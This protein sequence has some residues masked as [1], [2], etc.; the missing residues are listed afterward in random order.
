M[1]KKTLYCIIVILLAGIIVLVCGIGSSWFTNGDIRTWFNSWGQKDSVGNSSAGSSDDDNT[2]TE[3]KLE[4]FAFSPDTENKHISLKVTPYSVAVSSEEDDDGGESGD[5]FEE[6]GEDVDIEPVR[7]LIT[8]TV[9]TTVK[10]PKIDWTIE[11]QDPKEEEIDYSNIITLE[12]TEDGANTAIVTC[13]DAFDE[14]FIIK[15]TL[16]DVGVYGSCKVEFVGIPTEIYIVAGRSL[17]AIDEYEIDDIGTIDFTIVL[18]NVYHK[19]GERFYNF[20]SHSSLNGIVE[21]ETLD[22][23]MLGF[24]SKFVDKGR[25]SD[26]SFLSW[27]RGAIANQ[28]LI[29]KTSPQIEVVSDSK[30]LNDY[31]SSILMSYGVH[32]SIFTFT[33]NHSFFNHCAI[34]SNIQ[35]ELAN[36][37]YQTFVRFIE[38]PVLYLTVKEPIT[39]ISTELTLTFNPAL[40]SKVEISDEVVEF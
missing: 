24:G 22:I 32:D 10:D 16:R 3:E 13:Y 34:I 37:V 9:T 20:D 35:I 5:E 29:Q 19:V 33:L 23:S 11:V 25:L 2:E 30:T 6:G 31:D 38:E 1:T 40:F 28:N 12:P 4:D 39:G 7:K 27:V 21:Y 17:K 18:D 15:A 26:Q 8:A 36:R 14:T